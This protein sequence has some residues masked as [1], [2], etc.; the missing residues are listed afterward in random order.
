MSRKRSKGGSPAKK[1]ARSPKPKPKRKPKKKDRSE[2]AKKGW[3][4]RREKQRLLDKMVE[5]KLQQSEDERQPLGWTEHR[6][7]LRL[8]DDTIWRQ[9]SFDFDPKIVERKRLEILKE[10]EID[11]LTRGEL[12]D[13]LSWIAEEF[14]I[15][16]G[17]MYRMYLGYSVGETAAD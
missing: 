11:M 13:Y 17:D 2:S 9:I 7:K 15:E 12:Y 10:L 3:R 4:K 5:L 14:A 16:I 8:I 1:R 6:E